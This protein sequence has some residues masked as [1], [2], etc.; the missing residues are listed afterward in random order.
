MTLI[1]NRFGA[2]YKQLESAN[3]SP[4]ISRRC[5]T[6]SLETLLFFIPACFALNMA[7]GPNNLL[8]VANA[9]RHGFW[10]ASIA[11]AGRLLAFIGMIAI[12]ATGLAAVLQA[13]LAGF[14]VIKLIGAAYLFYLAFQL[15]RAKP[16]GQEINNTHATASLFS[17][18]RQEFLVAAGNPKAILIFTA[19]L[20]QFI[21]IAEPA[22]PQFFTL[23]TVFLFLEWLAIAAYACLGSHLRKWF[24]EPRSKQ[25]FNRICASL[26]GAAGLGLLLARR[27]TA[28]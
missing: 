5:T 9:T 16:Q 13:S 26:L 11:G 7:P 4:E 2:G 24:V 1:D 15:W 12:S 6:M 8:S 22:T 23:G 14:Y 10:V 20:P 17:L 21:D 28:V 27:S 3:V 19:F 18:A 25:I